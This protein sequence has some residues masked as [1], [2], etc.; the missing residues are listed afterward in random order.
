MDEIEE[1]D[2]GWIKLHRKIIKNLIFTNKDNYLI[3]LWVYILLSVNHEEKRI[4]FNEKEL[5]IKA[6]EGIFGLNQ[7]VRDCTGLQKIDSPKF[8]KF[9]TIYYRKLK[10]LENMQ[11]VKL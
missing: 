7:I 2:S 9:K 6:G 5:V 1:I 10:I 11:N 8:R 3:Q 4:I